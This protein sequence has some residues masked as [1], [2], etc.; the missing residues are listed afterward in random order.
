MSHIYFDMCICMYLYYVHV[1]KRHRE[2]PG[3]GD[4]D[5]DARQKD[6][7]WKKHIIPD[8]GRS[9]FRGKISFS[10]THTHILSLI[11]RAVHLRNVPV[12]Q[13]VLVWLS[14]KPLIHHASHFLIPHPFIPAHHHSLDTTLFLFLCVCLLLNTCLCHYRTERPLYSGRHQLCSWLLTEWW[15]R[16]NW[17]VQ[18]TKRKRLQG[19]SR[20][21]SIIKEGTWGWALLKTTVIRKIITLMFKAHLI[22]AVKDTFFS[23]L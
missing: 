7:R 17:Y 22:V 3:T 14:C 18:T 11:R 2:R 23:I 1:R 6:L 20:T 4:E 13:E 10:F 16:W 8:T 5:E 19:L 12:N 9:L 15:W 21:V